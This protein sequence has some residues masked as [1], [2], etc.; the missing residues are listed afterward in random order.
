MP[1][2]TVTAIQTKKFEIEVEADSPEQADTL[3][4]E[5]SDEDR[6][7]INSEDTFDYIVDGNGNTYDWSSVSGYWYKSNNVR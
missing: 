6:T 5:V 3:S 4:L 2:Y 1:K 7:L